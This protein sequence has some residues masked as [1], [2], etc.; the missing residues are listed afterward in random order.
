M[1]TDTVL[2]IFSATKPVTG[3]AVLQLVETGE[4]DLDAPAREYAPAIGDLR[5]LEGF[6]ADGEPRLRAP[7]SEPTTRQL[8]THTAGFGYDFFDEDYRRLAEEHGQPGVT[9]ATHAS[10]RTPLLFDPGTRWAYGSGVDWAG[11]VVEGIT[12]RRLGDVLRERVLEPLGMADTAFTLTEELRGRKATMHRRK[13]VG[14]YRPSG[15]ELPADPEVHMGGHGLW[16]TAAD[17]LR[18]LRMWLDDGSAPGGQVLRPA[19]V[20]MATRNHLDP[21][22]LIGPLHSVVPA[23]SD[24]VEFFPGVP[25]TW[26]LTFMVNE[27]DTATGRPA[28]ALAWAGLANLYFWIDR[29]HGVAGFWGTQVLPFGDPR[30]LEGYLAFETA[31]YDHRS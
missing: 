30:C 5:V 16:S 9:T 19:T 27:E 18:F 13:G 26:G 12:G 1:T 24:D 31:V 17:Y 25:K 28:G 3:T 21:G 15:F 2:A 7:R 11:Q 29:A 20:E 23:L 8:M 14:D 4:L 10:L 6:G 22:L